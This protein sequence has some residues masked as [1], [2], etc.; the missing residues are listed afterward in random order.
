MD[1]PTKGLTK[2]IIQ[3][4]DSDI[5]V[6]AISVVE[7]IKVEELWV[8]FGTGKHFGYT[9]AHVTA[10][11]LGADK[12]RVLPAFYTVTECD[13]VSLFGWKGKLKA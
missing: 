9:A 3:I 13:M 10:S 2:K 7:E 8:A 11:S 6:L 12:S 4:A 5:V 1:T